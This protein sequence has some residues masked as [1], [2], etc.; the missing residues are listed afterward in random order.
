M[1]V[2]RITGNEGR[3]AVIV[4]VQADEGEWRTMTFW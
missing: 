3:Y 2:V 4:A 1:P